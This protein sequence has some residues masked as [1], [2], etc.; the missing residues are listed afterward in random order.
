MFHDLDCTC[1]DCISPIDDDRYDEDDK[2]EEE[3]G[4]DSLDPDEE[5]DSAIDIDLDSANEAN[6]NDADQDDPQDW[7]SDEDAQ[8][9]F[10]DDLQDMM[11]RDKRVVTAVRF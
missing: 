8:K 6:G 2:D 1:M 4:C 3:E 5:L 9:T 11:M 7:D 10:Y